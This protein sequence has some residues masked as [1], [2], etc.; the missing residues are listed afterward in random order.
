MGGGW[1]SIFVR[2]ITQQVTVGIACGVLIPY[3]ETDDEHSLTLA[4]EDQDGAHITGPLTVKFK[5]GRPPTLDRGAFMHLPFA[6][7]AEYPL[8]AYGTYIVRATVDN[9]P[10][11]T[12]ST[13]FSAR[14][15][16]GA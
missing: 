7:K 11:A 6:I 4:L 16:V 15:I 8:P 9:N 1:D 14:P 2:D 5:T 13:S 3:G 12:R 10:E